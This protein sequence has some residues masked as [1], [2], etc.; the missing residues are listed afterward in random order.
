MKTLIIAKQTKYEYEKEKFKLSHEEICQKYKS[1]H[2]NL[3]AI[4]QSH[5]RQIEAREKLAK[6]LPKSEIKLMKDLEQITD[7][8]AIISLG[9]DNSF[10]Y[11]SHYVDEIPIFGV[12]SDPARS[13]GA[14]CEWTDLEQLANALRE[15]QYQ[16][17]GWTRLSAD[18]DGKK[19]SSA[20]SEYFFGETR[21]KSMSRQVIEW[22]GQKIEQKSSGIIISTGAGSTGW[23][24]S[25]GGKPFSR[26]QPLAKFIV[27]E[28]YRTNLFSG[29]IE[30]GETLTIHSLNDEEGCASADSW[31]DYSFQRGQSAKIK[32]GKPLFVAKPRKK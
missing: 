5:S 10:T 1:E 20:T 15:N 29:E 7:Y 32:I 13:T 9:G 22:R 21:R 16:T 11:I 12:N 26:T 24:N 30:K 31:E 4:I 18:I 17:E 28:P 2:A 6:L 14:L 8:D 25:A 27:T 3:E 23:Y 19:I